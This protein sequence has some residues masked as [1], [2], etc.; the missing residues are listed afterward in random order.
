MVEEVAASAGVVG[1]EQIME[2]I[3]GRAPRNGTRRGKV[4]RD[5]FVKFWLAAQTASATTCAYPKESNPLL[6]VQNV[7]ENGGGSEP[8]RGRGR[9]Q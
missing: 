8:S 6:D 2:E 9:P 5:N 7:G 3:R 4:F 1:G